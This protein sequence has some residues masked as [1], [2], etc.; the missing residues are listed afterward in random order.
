MENCL[1]YKITKK[2]GITTV[3]TATTTETLKIFN[4]HLSLL[5][6]LNDVALIESFYN[7]FYFSNLL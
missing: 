2:K 3:T 1:C 6:I 4:A 7:N 5:K